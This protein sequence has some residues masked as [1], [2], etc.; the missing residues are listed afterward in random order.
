MEESIDFSGNKLILASISVLVYFCLKKGH[1]F[2]QRSPNFCRI[3]GKIAQKDICIDSSGNERF[4]PF[5]GQLCV[6][7]H[8][9]GGPRE[10]TRHTPKQRPFLF[11]SNAARNPPRQLSSWW[12]S[13]QK[14]LTDRRGFRKWSAWG[15]EQGGLG[16]AGG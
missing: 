16:G 3:T 9:R 7:R 12:L 14:V 15:A 11:L 1:F 2:L 10:N 4:D 6:Q 5:D 13:R 8:L